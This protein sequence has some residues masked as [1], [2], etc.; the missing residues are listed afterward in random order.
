MAEIITSK[1]KL[2]QLEAQ[3]KAAELEH[4]V[5]GLR[6]QFAPAPLPDGADAVQAAAHQVL[7]TETQAN[8][9]ALLTW[10]HKLSVLRPIYE[11]LKAEVSKQDRPKA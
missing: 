7:E 6:V 8:Q 10:E 11:T 1:D 9:A 4:F 3:I 5:L 2:Q